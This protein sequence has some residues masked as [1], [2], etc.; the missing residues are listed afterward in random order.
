M[1]KNGTRQ[2]PVD[3]A[4]EAAVTGHFSKFEF[5]NYDEELKNPKIVNNGHSSEYLKPRNSRLE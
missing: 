2:S 3:L 1:C 5:K 4:H